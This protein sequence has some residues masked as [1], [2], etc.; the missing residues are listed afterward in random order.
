MGY[1]DEGYK[2]EERKHL[3]PGNHRVKI[4]AVEEGTSKTSRNPMLIITIQPNDSDVKIKHYI[5]KNEYYN[6]NMTE[7][8]DSFGI[9]KDDFVFLTWPGAMGAARLVEDENGYLK[10]RFFLAPEKQDKLPP[11]VGPIPQRQA[12][13]EA[14]P[15]LGD[16]DL[17]DTDD[18]D[19]LPF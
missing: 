3:E 11:W 19:G 16:D 17:P 1:W 2:R 8:K 5:V 13:T 14:P 7:L 9:A 18:E 6:R 12:M 10:A 15:I 4:T